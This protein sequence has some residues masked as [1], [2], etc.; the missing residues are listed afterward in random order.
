MIC[1][2]KT[3]LF[4]YKK[5]STPKKWR[6]NW[7]DWRDF[8]KKQLSTPKNDVMTARKMALIDC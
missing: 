6:C 3:L 7:R 4:Y 2:L 1:S 8:V 5:M